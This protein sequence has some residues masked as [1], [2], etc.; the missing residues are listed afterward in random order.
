MEKLELAVEVRSNVGKGSARQA[1]RELKIPGVYY[2][3]HMKGAQA[4]AVNEREFMRLLSKSK[5]NSIYTFKS[6]GPL[7][8]KMVLLKD[9][10]LDPIKDSF[11]HV[12][13][14]EVR[15]NEK[16]KVSVAVVLTGKSIGVSEGGILQHIRRELDVRCLPNQIPTQIEVDVSGVKIGDSLHMNDI[17][18]PAGISFVGTINHTIVAVVPPQE[19]KAAAAT[20]AAAAPAEGAAAAAAPAAA[21][22]DAKAAPAKDAKAPAEKKDAKK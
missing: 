6:D 22:K 19:E 17:K 11:T 8:G 4:I 10:Q 9:H 1:R 15:E 18:L 3:P 20:T 16:I 7:N 21:G 5:N 2:G 13:F 14:V 12:D